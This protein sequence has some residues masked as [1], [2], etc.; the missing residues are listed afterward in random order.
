MEVTREEEHDSGVNEGNMQTQ[1]RRGEEIMKGN[2]RSATGEPQSF[3]HGHLEFYHAD[4]C[5]IT[6]TG[7]GETERDGS[8]EQRLRAACVY[9]PQK[10]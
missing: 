4:P 2:W 3:G 10:M 7:T 9:S 8:M 6:L 1:R 5:L